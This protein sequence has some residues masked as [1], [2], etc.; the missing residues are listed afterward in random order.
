MYV[1][2]CS[3]L[4][5]LLHSV[6]AKD[7]LNVTVTEDEDAILTC[8]PTV[9]HF[10]FGKLTKEVE[11]GQIVTDHVGNTR[12]GNIFTGVCHSVQGVKILRGTC[13]STSN[14]KLPDLTCDLPLLAPPII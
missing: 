4:L 5:G 11:H 10:L 9:P 2:P 12:E 6:P 13:H 3:H 8:N 7:Q 14:H 1:F